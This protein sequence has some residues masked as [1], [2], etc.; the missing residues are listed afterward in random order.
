MK[1]LVTWLKVR[2]AAISEVTLVE[3]VQNKVQHFTFHRQ[4]PRNDELFFSFFSRFSITC[5]SP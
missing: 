1:P 3:K 4:S 2:R 5:S